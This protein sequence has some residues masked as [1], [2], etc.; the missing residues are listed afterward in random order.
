[1]E[2]DRE[3]T[4]IDLLGAAGRW[5]RAGHEGL[6]PGRLEWAVDTARELMSGQ[7]PAVTRPLAPFCLIT[8]GPHLASPASLVCVAARLLAFGVIVRGVHRLNNTTTD[9]VGA[10]YPRAARHFTH[11]PSAPAHWEHLDRRFAT[12]EFERIFGRPYDRSLVV[13]GKRII[14]DSPL[15]S[16]GLTEIWESGRRPVTRALLTSRYGTKAA[17]F[18]LGSRDRYAWFRGTLPVGIS[19]IGPAM[20]AFAMRDERLL[21]G[22]PVIVVNGHVPGLAALFTPEC[23]MFELGI[24]LGG[25]AIGDIR[26]LLVGADGRPDQCQPG[27]LRRDAC[28]GDLPLSSPTPVN[29]RLNLIHCSDGLL[30]GLLEAQRLTPTPRDESD[31]LTRRLFRDGLTE[32]EMRELVWSDPLVRPDQ[33][34]GYLTDR[35]AGLGLDACV[36]EIL[37]AVPPVFGPANGGADGVGLDLVA[38]TLQRALRG[39]PSQPEPRGGPLTAIAAPGDSEEETGQAAI[40]Q[41]LVGVLIP[42]GGTGGRFGGYERPESDPARQKALAPLFHVAGQRLSALDIRLA[43]VRYWDDSESGRV[44]AAVLTSA[45]S[46]A[47]LGHWRA[48]LD[49]PYCKI[50]KLFAQHGLYRLDAALAASVAP[51]RWFDAILR[52]RDGRPSLKPSGPLGLFSAFVLSGLLDDWER[53]GVRYLAVANGDDVGFRLDPRAV[54][55]LERHSATDALIVAVPWGWSGVVHGVRIR[56]DASGWA[57]TESGGPVSTPIL[58]AEQRPDS[59]GAVRR[60]RGPDGVTLTIVETQRPGRD[61]FNTGQVY[62]RLAALR[63]LLAA[64]GSSSPLEAVR[65]ITANVPASVEEKVVAAGRARQIAQPFHALLSLLCKCD[66][67]IGTRQLGPGVRSSHATLKRPEDL[68]FAQLIV[69]GLSRHQNEL[70][71]APAWSA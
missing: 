51:E 60:R 27:S 2:I 35:T 34:D 22:D 29:S 46:A 43:N 45:T 62:L 58:V 42:A 40:G 4:L 18:V 55:H 67:L 16:A 3:L 23:W 10:L 57:V 56:G 48:G 25:A 17:G 68:P 44:P 26:R 63:R 30:A 28:T 66:V 64:T 49:H 36:A 52:D 1:M 19:R 14:D 70:I 53:R 5:S 65:R 31:P 32:Q 20:T 24:E 61:L 38:R 15:T 54:G 21:G 37:A 41:G 11:G 47:G 6:A 9:I 33:L 71:V 59:G 50:V 7:V 69:D 12:P 8:K 39:V 13:P